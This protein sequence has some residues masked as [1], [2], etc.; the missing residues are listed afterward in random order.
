MRVIATAVGYDGI[1]IRHPGEEFDMPE[2]AAGSWFR[3]KGRE[4]DAPGD[5]GDQGDAPPAP[6]PAGARRGR[7]AATAAPPPGDGGD[8]GDAA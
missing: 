1:C 3:P 5:G 8:Q 7:R 4:G 6:A 2:D